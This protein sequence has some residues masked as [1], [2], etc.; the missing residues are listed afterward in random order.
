M[1]SLNLKQNKKV[2]TECEARVARGAPPRHRPQKC[3]AGAVVARADPTS[4]VQPTCLLSRRKTCRGAQTFN[5]HPHHST[6]FQ[7]FVKL[8]YPCQVRCPGNQVWCYLNIHVNIYKEY[9]DKYSCKYSHE[10]WN[11][12]EIF[13]SPKRIF[14]SYFLFWKIFF[15]IFNLNIMNIY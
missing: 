10:Y 9:S 11:E 5:P 2:F 6:L 1:A 14:K 15:W 7:V 12:M 13:I 8:P 4:Q 3:S